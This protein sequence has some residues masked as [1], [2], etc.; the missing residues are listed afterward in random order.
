ME[1]LH[2]DIC[3][4]SGSLDGRMVQEVM[5]AGESTVGLLAA[6]GCNRNNVLI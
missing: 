2:V 6:A 4:L 5:F 3:S 1:L